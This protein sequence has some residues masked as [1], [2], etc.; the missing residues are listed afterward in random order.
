MTSLQNAVVLVTGANGGLGHEFVEQ[1]LARGAQRVY[2]TARSPRAWADERVT[3]L[4]LDVTSSS[5]IRDAAALAPGTTVVINNAGIDGSGPLLGSDLDDIRRIFETNVF[6]ALEVAQVFAPI[7][8]ANGGGALVDVHSA[9]SW[10]GRAGAYSATKAAFWSLTNSLRL[11]SRGQGTQVVGA[12]LAYADTPMASHLTV[13]KTDPAEIVAAIYA[14]LE[15][16]ELE[17]LADETTRQVKAALSL[18]ISAL[19]PEFA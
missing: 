11:E 17:V 3:P 8:A 9:L 1:A 5:S 6:G 15:D 4:T 10:L 2:A 12:H 18:P 19:Y 7:L 16:G 14:G 13:E